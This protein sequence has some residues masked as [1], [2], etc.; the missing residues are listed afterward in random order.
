MLRWVLA[1]V[2]LQLACLSQGTRQ[3]NEVRDTHADGEVLQ[4]VGEPAETSE[5][6]ADPEASV[7][8]PCIATTPTRIAFG[9]NEIGTS[10]IVTLSI[11]S[12]GDSA[13]VIDAV[14][15]TNDGGGVF[16]V[17]GAVGRMTL[18]PGVTTSVAVSFTPKMAAGFDAAGNVVRTEGALSIVSNAGAVT[19][20]LEGFGRH[21]EC[22]V[23]V[24]TVA[25]GE[26]VLPGTNLS[27]SGAS[28]VATG[29]AT[30]FEWSVEQPGGSVSTFLPSSGVVSPRFEVN[31]VG[32]YIFRLTVRDRFGT[33]SCAPAEYTVMVAGDDSITVEVIWDTPGDP[34][35]QDTSDPFDQTPAGSDVDLHFLH[36]IANGK[37]FDGTFDCYFANPNPNWGEPGTFDDPRL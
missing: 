23:A 2:L 19:V 24:I 18:E 14:S 33:A 31:V 25:E 17:E 27:L 5:P 16:A 7:A 11:R 22:P 9:A 10:S 20:P 8:E 1:V 6:D 35:Q 4:E 29:G 26:E 30:S 28:S 32:Q 15:I 12:C 21:F 13:L 37:L 34:N 3:E 36:P